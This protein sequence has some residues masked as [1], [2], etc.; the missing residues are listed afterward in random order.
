MQYFPG[1]ESCPVPLIRRNC[2]IFGR[3]EIGGDSLLLFLMLLL[4]H[5]W[6]C[7]I[8]VSFCF[9]F[10]CS[11]I[12]V[13]NFMDVERHF[14]SGGILKFVS[15]IHLIQADTSD[16]L[17]YFIE[18]EHTYRKVHHHALMTWYISQP[19]HMNTHVMASLSKNSMKKSSQSPF[20]SHHIS[21]EGIATVLTSGF[22]RY[23]DGII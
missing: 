10:S 4:I 13:S 16:V 21:L 17:K 3:W 7:D 15:Q 14:E 2:T 19:D 6:C 12:A 22:G 18:V 9:V 23:I 20:P 11:S 1:Y 8:L 5:R